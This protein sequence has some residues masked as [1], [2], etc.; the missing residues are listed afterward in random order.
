MNDQDE[1][2]EVWAEVIAAI[3]FLRQIGHPELTVWNV[4]DEA[5][6]RW[7]SPDTQDQSD[8]WADPDPLRGS[9]ETL[10]R[11]VGS[12]GGYGAVAI[13]TVFTSALIDW[14]DGARRDHNDGMPF[15]SRQLGTG[16]LLETPPVSEKNRARQARS[17][18]SQL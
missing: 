9:I 13:S 3:E 16:L 7:I 15:G 11:H 6:R 12:A 5:V 1:S 14:L 4:F 18:M 10:F 2:T 17:E 8:L